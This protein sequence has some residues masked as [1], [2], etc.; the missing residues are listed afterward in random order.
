[1]RKSLG[2]ILLVLAAP[3][4]RIKPRRSLLDQDI[5][6]GPD[7]YCRPPGNIH[8]S[9]DSK[10]IPSPAR[11]GNRL[12]RRR[13]VSGTRVPAPSQSLFRPRETRLAAVAR[14]NAHTAAGTP[15]RVQRHLY[16]D[17]TPN[18]QAPHQT[19]EASASSVLRRPP[20]FFVRRQLYSI[21][22]LHRFLRHIPHPPGPARD[23]S[24]RRNRGRLSSSTRSVQLYGIGFARHHRESGRL[25]RDLWAQAGLA[26]EGEQSRTFDLPTAL[27]A[28]PYATRPRPRPPTFLYV[29]RSG[30]TEELRVRR[31]RDAEHRGASL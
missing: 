9:A 21:D 16:T 10:W 13:T 14:A 11:A 19:V 29:T 8:W 12:A 5:L 25:Q 23:S 6:R 28:D 30:Y 26:P 4:L 22:S 31:R 3:W 18:D 1:M 24:S 7:L 15:R 17:L 2:L 20:V 27:A